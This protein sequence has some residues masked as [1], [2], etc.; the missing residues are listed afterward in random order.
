MLLL[1][2]LTDCVIKHLLPVYWTKYVHPTQ[3]SSR[4]NVCHLS[5]P[6]HDD[7]ST[8]PVHAA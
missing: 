6:G 2:I 3:T 8:N 5:L 4:V 1:I 7:A